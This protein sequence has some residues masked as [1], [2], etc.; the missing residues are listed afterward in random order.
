LQTARSFSQVALID[1]TP[2]SLPHTSNVK[3]QQQQQQQQASQEN[4]KITM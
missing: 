3:R 1:H 2:L 4:N